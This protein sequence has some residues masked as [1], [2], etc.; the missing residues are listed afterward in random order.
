M[1]K[2]IRSIQINGVEYNANRDPQFYRRT[3]NEPFSIELSVSGAGRAEATLEIAG[4]GDDAKSIVLP[5][6]VAWE[7]RFESAGTRVGRVTVTCDDQ[8]DHRELR[9]DVEAHAWVG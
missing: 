8:S 1:N 4:E 7:A 6:R 9:F 3:V 5:G 2:L